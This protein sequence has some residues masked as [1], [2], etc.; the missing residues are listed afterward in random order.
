[1]SEREIAHFAH[2]RELIPTSLAGSDTC[3]SLLV[4]DDQIE[5]MSNLMPYAH[6][7]KSWNDETI[8]SEMYYLPSDD[9]WD[10]LE[11]VIDD[12][13]FRLMDTCGTPIVVE[14][15]DQHLNWGI[16]INEDG[17]VGDTRIEGVSDPNLLL[18]DAEQNKVGIGVPAFTAGGGKLEINGA[19]T[20][21]ALQP[22]SADIHTLDDYE[23]FEVVVTMTAG[24]S[25]TITL[26]GTSKTL[27]YTK[28]G[29]V[30]HITGVLEVDSVSSPVGLLMVLDLPFAA[31]AGNQFSA[32]VSIRCYNLI[33]TATTSIVAWIVGGEAAIRVH[34]FAAG[35][36]A[37]MAADVQA[38]SQFAISA[39]YFTAT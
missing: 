8:D 1:M 33:A 11:A 15:A 14:N 26:K 17:N 28:I 34:K 36:V 19:I 20:F 30:V 12:L 29:R 25:G 35:T 9:D 39:T 7:R 32:A 6:D 38:G 24:T 23:E 31:A 18:V 13:E 21:P 4:T 27:A 10:E 37:N 2:K 3:R 22:A 5:I 16:T